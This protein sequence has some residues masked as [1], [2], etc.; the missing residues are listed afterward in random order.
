M[1]GLDLSPFE[2]MMKGIA[3]ACGLVVAAVL[4]DPFS[5]EI[6]KILAALLLLP[7]IGEW[8]EGRINYKSEPFLERGYRVFATLR[9]LSKVSSCLSAE[10]AKSKENS[11]V[12]ILQLD[13]LPPDSIAALTLAA[14]AATGGRGL[15]VLVDKSGQAQI[16]PAL[17]TDID[18]ARKLFDLN[19]WAPLAMV[20]AFTPFL[21]EARGCL[22]NNASVSAYVPMPFSGTYGASKAALVLRS[23]VPHGEEPDLLLS[24][25]FSSRP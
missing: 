21:M 12:T 7:Q 23:S 10:A 22:V 3:P 2:K 6:F 24:V 13:V 5:S 1:V 9:N 17:D 20:Q 18:E 8:V 14:A 25:W 15:D 19:F 4:L 16:L 11:N